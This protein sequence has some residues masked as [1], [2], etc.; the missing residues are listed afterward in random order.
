MVIKKAYVL[1]FVFASHYFNAWKTYIFYIVSSSYRKF[2]KFSSYLMVYCKNLNVLE[3][4][5]GLY[6]FEYKLNVP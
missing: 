1:I 4:N 2:G 5:N 6:N 3:R